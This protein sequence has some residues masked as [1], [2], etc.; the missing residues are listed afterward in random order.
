[1]LNRTLIVRTTN[2]SL[3]T[4]APAEYLDHIRTTLGA[5]RFQELL[6]SHLLPG[7][8]ESPLWRND[9]EG[10]LARRQEMVWQEIQRVT[11]LTH[12]MPMLD[13]IAPPPRSRA[14]AN[15]P[16]TLCHE[17]ASGPATR[18]H[19]LPGLEGYLASQSDHTRRLLKA[20]DHGIRALAP[21][22]EAQTTKGRRC[23]GGMSYYSPERLFFCADFLRTGDG[24]TLSV[25]TGGQRWEGL[26]PSRTTPRGYYILRS[27]ADLPQA[28]AWAKAAYEARKREP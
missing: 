25:F 22:I 21:D 26:N 7:E 4:R 18:L 24:L 20:L 17:H 6:Q 28:L 13:A 27:E 2:K 3:H 5:G 11:G 9:F 15:A 14:H 10:F 1:V 12:A 8:P 23:L 16:V 19:A